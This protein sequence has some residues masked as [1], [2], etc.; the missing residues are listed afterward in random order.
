[1]DKIER[2]QD[3]KSVLKSAAFNESFMAMRADIV[4]SWSR[5]TNFF[6]GRREREKLHAKMVILNELEDKLRLMIETAER[7]QDAVANRERL[8]KVRRL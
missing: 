7:A 3:A 6:T 2:G 5:G 1:M 4:N 8:S